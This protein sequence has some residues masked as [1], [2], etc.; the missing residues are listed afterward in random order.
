VLPLVALLLRAPWGSLGRLLSED[1][2]RTALRLSLEC[3][4]AAT[5][6]SLALGVPL[7]WVLAR[8]KL[9]GLA[10]IRAVVTLPLVLLAIPSAVV[11]FLAI[12]PQLFGGFF[13]GAIFV[14]AARHPAMHE[15]AEE[16]HGAAEMALHGLTGLPFWLALAGVVVAYVCYLARPDIPAAIKSRTVFINRVLDNKYYFDWFNENVIA[17]GARWFGQGLWK[18]ADLGF[19]DGALVN[20]SARAVGAVAGVV[21]LVQTGHLYWYALVM[22]LGVVGL[23]TWQLWPFLS[24][25]LMR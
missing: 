18:G 23:M 5:V 2:V 15:L 13:D 22:I 10:F 7:A 3:A 20:G 4:T 11:G 14:D 25:L 6:I 1:E 24:G 12:G 17:A 21:R 9:P 16:F 19:I 8:A